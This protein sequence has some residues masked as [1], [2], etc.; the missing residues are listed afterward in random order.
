MLYNRYNGI[1]YIGESSVTFD[2]WCNSVELQFD[3]ATAKGQ[4]QFKRW[5][6]TLPEKLSDKPLG[7]IDEVTG[8]Q[9]IF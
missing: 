3:L 1:F 4:R 7:K 2:R 5:F 8:N 9:I 6:E